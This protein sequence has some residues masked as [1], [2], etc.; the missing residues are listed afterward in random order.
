MQ[1]WRHAWNKAAPLIS[2]KA[3][4]ALRRALEDDDVRL[5]QQRTTHPTALLENHHKPCGGA[6]LLGFCGMAEG[7]KTVEEVEGYFARMCFE[8][9]QKMG[10]PAGV[11]WLLNFWDEEQREFAFCAILAA[12]CEELKGR[13]GHAA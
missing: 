6:C 13:A 3:L 12:V 10:E 7:L 8:I 2:T 5:I 1:P 9:D 4:T 11:R